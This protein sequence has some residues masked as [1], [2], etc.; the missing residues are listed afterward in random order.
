[1]AYSTLQ[2]NLFYIDALLA[3]IAALGIAFA[4][5]RTSGPRPPLAERGTLDLRTWNFAD[6]GSA[7]PC[8]VV[9]VRIPIAA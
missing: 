4:S 1:M 3:A 6:S 5:G 8:T 9:T 7:G 2:R